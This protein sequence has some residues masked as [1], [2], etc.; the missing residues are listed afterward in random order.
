MYLHT[1]VCSGRAR[2]WLVVSCALLLPGCDSLMGT[3]ECGD[4][5]S[6]PYFISHGEPLQVPV[7]GN[8]VL[9]L[10]YGYSAGLLDSC[11]LEISADASWSSSNTS[12]A[13]IGGVVDAGGSQARVIE[14]VA[15]GF[16][17]IT[18]TYRGRSATHAVEVCIAH[19]DASGWSC[20]SPPE[21]NVMEG[22]P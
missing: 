14:G 15:E 19:G 20:D 10:N 21:S 6:Q 18:G 4:S 13:R 22:H 1:C 8:N 9:Q 7:G 2:S 11:I 3:E 12:I 17:T 5:R 16:A